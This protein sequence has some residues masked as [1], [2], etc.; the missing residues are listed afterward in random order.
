MVGNSSS[1]IIEA[2]SF[3]LPVIN[4]GS[5]QTGR[6]RAKNVIDVGY[7]KEQIIREVQKIIK[8]PKK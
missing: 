2:P 8:Q 3:G 5:R 1:G 4:I 6:Q 7:N